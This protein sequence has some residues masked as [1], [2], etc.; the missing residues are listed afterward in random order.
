MKH[1][2]STV[3]IKIALVGAGLA[4]GVIGA[5]AIGAGA[6]TTSGSPSS[7]AST[8][9]PSSPD[10]AGEGPGRGFDGDH[11]GP[12]GDPRGDH[13]GPRP[14]RG[15]EKALSASTA[16]TLKAAA[17]KAVPGGTVYRVETDSGDAAYEVHMTKAGGTEVTV[18]FTKALK[19]IK[20]EA[21]MGR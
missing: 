13:R 3:G 6:Q 11:D 21:G 17:L 1:L 16:A 5:S 10:R 19:L 2:L 8:A 18:K 12:L 7:P 4:V 14:V 9:A 15:D 20:V